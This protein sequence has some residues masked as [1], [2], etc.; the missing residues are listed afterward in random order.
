MQRFL[1]TWNYFFILVF[2]DL[3]EGRQGAG[4]FEIEIEMLPTE[5]LGANLITFGE[6]L[7]GAKRLL[8]SHIR[9]GSIADRC[10]CV[11]FFVFYAF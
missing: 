2:A 11:F 5:R 3:V 6:N 10:F 8:I 4:P 1:Y 9:D 7:Q